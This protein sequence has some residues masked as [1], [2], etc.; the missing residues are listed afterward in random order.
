M[1]PEPLVLTISFPLLVSV[2]AI[3][4][5]DNANYSTKFVIL[6]SSLASLFKYLSLAGVL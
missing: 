1:L 5:S 3:L 4:F 2:K 6:A